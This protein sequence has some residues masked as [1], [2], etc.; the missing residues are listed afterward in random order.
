M[1]F[2][3]PA[4]FL[5]PMRLVFSHCSHHVHDMLLMLVRGYS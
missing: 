1:R 2:Y 5:F 4:V 3:R